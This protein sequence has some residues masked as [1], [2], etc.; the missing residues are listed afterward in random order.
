M[1]ASCVVRAY[2]ADGGFVEVE[3]PS[4][5]DA[6]N[7]VELPSLPEDCIFGDN[8]AHSIIESIEETEDMPSAAASSSSSSAVAVANPNE[9]SIRP[10]PDGPF[11]S[12]L[13]TGDRIFGIQFDGGTAVLRIHDSVHSESKG[14]VATVYTD[15]TLRT[16]LG[17]LSTAMPLSTSDGLKACCDTHNIRKVKKKCQCW[18]RLKKTDRTPEKASGILRSLA[19]WLGGSTTKTREE[20]MQESQTLRI[21]AGMNIRDTTGLHSHTHHVCVRWKHTYPH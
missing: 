15:R 7:G 9:T 8:G 3:E 13:N 11:H 1:I 17:T 5:N 10:L 2:E 16:R 14:N 6:L 12:L 4:I 18:I 20:H 21:A 19:E